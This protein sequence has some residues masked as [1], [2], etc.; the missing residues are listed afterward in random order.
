M[1]ASLPTMSRKSF[2]NKRSIA[3]CRWA[4]TLFGKP[5]KCSRNSGNPLKLCSAHLPEQTSVAVSLR[6]RL[7]LPSPRR[8]EFVRRGPGLLAEKAGEVGRIGEGK[9]VGDLVDRLAGEH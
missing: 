4:I 5:A 8:A 7:R 1:A 9:I 3:G 6:G 2:C